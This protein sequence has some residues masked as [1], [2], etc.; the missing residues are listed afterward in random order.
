MGKRQGG[1][2]GSEEAMHRGWRSSTGAGKEVVLLIQA[3]P[4]RG[5][6]G[7]GPTAT[8]C[9]LAAADLTTGEW[10]RV[11]VST[12]DTSSSSGLCA[13]RAMPDQRRLRAGRP[14]RSVVARR[15]RKRHDAAG[16][17]RGVRE[18]GK[19]ELGVG[20]AVVY[21]RRETH[22]PLFHLPAALCRVAGRP[23]RVP[24]YAAWSPRAAPAATPPSRCP[25]PR[26]RQ[27][28]REELG[29]GA[30]VVYGHRE[31][32]QPLLYLPAALCRVAGRLYR[33]PPCAARSPRAAPSR[34]RERTSPAACIASHGHREPRRLLLHLPA[35]LCRVAGRPYRARCYATQSP[36]AAPSRKREREEGE[37]EEEDRERERKGNLFKACKKLGEVSGT[38]RR[39]N[40]LP[41]RG[42]TVQLPPPIA[43]SPRHHL[44]FANGE[45]REGAE[46]GRDG[47][48]RES[49]RG[50][51]G[52]VV[53]KWVN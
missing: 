26:R 37:R 48:W 19:E 1:G 7:K 22:R 31:P 41:L 16:Q 9:A 15:V 14:R 27:R 11:E 10:R 28:G 29:V 49:E 24:P 3:T 53:A 38:A 21:G 18:R 43:V 4:A 51:S 20:A 23:Y 30:A 46:P 8:E 35:A 12:D 25:L 47:S 2:D 5:G 13:G 45:W 36:R 44:G 50:L 32:R 42:S 34:E 17:P 40:G 52:R 33:A 6:D 39:G